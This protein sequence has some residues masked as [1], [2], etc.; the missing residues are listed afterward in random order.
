MRRADPMSAL[1]LLGA[2]PEIDALAASERNLLAE[3]WQRRAEN[4]LRTSTVFANLYRALV[5]DRACAAV[6][7]IASSAINDELR[8]AEIAADVAARYGGRSPRL[9]AVTPVEAPYFGPFELHG[10]TLFA[11]LQSCLNETVAAAYLAMC[12]GEARAAITR[13]A[14]HAILQ[15]EVQHS[16]LGWA[17]LASRPGDGAMG[18]VVSQALP[19]LLTAVAAEWLTDPNGDY[20]R[21]RVGHGTLAPSE[22][23]V[24][25]SDTLEGVILPGFEHVGIDAR[26]AREWAAA[27]FPCVPEGTA[28]SSR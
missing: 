6:L 17:H 7:S 23:R 3:L 28:P 10:A 9:P 26:P 5:A 13:K 11:V 25:L 21:A 27:A 15:D 16:R 2:D 20:A 4:E 24:V 8:H 19:T 14:L 12:R 22:M 1:E 18:H